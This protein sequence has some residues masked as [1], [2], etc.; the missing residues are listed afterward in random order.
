MVFFFFLKII[1][2]VTMTHIYIHFYNYTGDQFAYFNDGCK[3]FD[4]L[5][6]HPNHFSEI[7]FNGDPKE[8]LNLW[9]A[10]FESATIT[11]SR[12]MI[13]FNFLIR[14]ISFG[15][16]YIHIAIFC[17][18]AFSG[19]TCAI[20]YFSKYFSEKTAAI[21]FVV[22]LFP[23]ILFWTSGIQK[24]S[25][26]VF[27]VGYIIYKTEFGSLT[28]YNKPQL[29]FIFSAFCFLFFFKMYLVLI[30][31]PILISN[32]LISKKIIKRG[33]NSFIAVFSLFILVG[34]FSEIIFK[35]PAFFAAIADKRAKAISEARGGV[36][37]YSET[38]F[39]AVDYL[40][41]DK[42]LIPESS[43][44]YKIKQ[45]SSFL[46][47]E[48]NNMKDT[49]FVNDSKDTSLYRFL[50][51]VVP[52]K[53]VIP[54][55]KIE[56][57]SIAIIAHVPE[58]IYNCFFYPTIAQTKSN[59]HLFQFIENIIVYIFILIPIFFFDKQSLKNKTVLF[60]S[61]LFCFSVFIIIG[62]TT[63]TVGS[64]VRYKTV[65]MIFFIPVLLASTDFN[66]IKAIVF[67]IKKQ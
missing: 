47:W 46:K 42:I 40:Q 49:T 54:I 2:G 24:E 9:I 33:R 57:N 38:N 41:K 32:F 35:K 19:L 23:S 11:G 28:S 66:K 12:I 18:V 7:V 65:G 6:E 37:L 5:L 45:G 60:S 29:L 13:L 50:Y 22:F 55:Q 39:I 31:F 62:L 61:I 25:L 52:A 67:G 17:F 3:L 16:I 58:A 8:E 36:F 53:T 34:V 56:P 1:A 51:E 14:F 15:N 4:I 21:A 44:S 20:K 30:L 48:W 64:I 43:E 26:V 10:P 63:P 27:L 59:F